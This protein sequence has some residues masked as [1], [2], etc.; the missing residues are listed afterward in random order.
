MKKTNINLFGHLLIFLKFLLEGVDT[1]AQL[2]PDLDDAS[3]VV[4]QKSGWQRL[5]STP[6]SPPYP[7]SFSKILETLL[8]FFTM[9]HYSRRPWFDS[10]N[11]QPNHS[12]INKKAPSRALSFR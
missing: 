8:A 7:C 4:Q 3:Y 1:A 5:Y 6:E 12:A 9:E 2:T 11:P 10:F